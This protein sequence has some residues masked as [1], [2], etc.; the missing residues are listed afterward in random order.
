MNYKLLGRSYA[1]QTG[2]RTCYSDRAVKLSLAGA[3][4]GTTVSVGARS[5]PLSGGCAMIPPDAFSTGLNRVSFR[6]GEE[7]VP[8][9]SVI[10]TA[11][12]LSP[13]GA[14]LSDVILALDARIAALGERLAAA[15]LSLEL[16]LSEEGLFE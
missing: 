7:T 1:L 14:S 13:A 6:V 12:G 2:G 9:E 11:A 16:L 5:F 10:K 15:L 3:P 4:E 8:A